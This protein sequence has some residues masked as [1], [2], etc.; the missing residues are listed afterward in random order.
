[1]LFVRPGERREGGIRGETGRAG[2][3]E[4]EVMKGTVECS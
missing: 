4:A 3:E 1:M 2:G